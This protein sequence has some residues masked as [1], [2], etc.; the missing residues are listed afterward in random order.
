MERPAKAPEEIVE[1]GPPPEDPEDMDLD[2][3]E[4]VEILPRL[5]LEL[6]PELPPE[7]PL[8]PPP[9]LP[10]PPPPLRPPPPPPPPPLRP[11]PPPP[12]P[13]PPPP[14]PPP[15]PPFLLNRCRFVEEF[16]VD[17]EVIKGTYMVVSSRLKVVKKKV[18]NPMMK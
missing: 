6:P 18:E 12:P 15:P 5:P 8:L 2:G 16:E 1:T 17:N 9:L 13:L 7:P 4:P 3:P 11:P 14:P 10:P